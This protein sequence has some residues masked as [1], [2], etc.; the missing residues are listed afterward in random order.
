MLGVEVETAEEGVRRA[1]KPPLYHTT[2][3]D[4]E[5]HTTMCAACNKTWLA[6][7]SMPIPIHTYRRERPPS[8]LCGSFAS[9]SLSLSVS[10]SLQSVIRCQLPVQD[11]REV[12]TAAATEA[13]LPQHWAAMRHPAQA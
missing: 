11:A 8:M 13:L 3:T 2:P 12:W 1:T 6:A 4:D 10:C 5:G 9:L 7:G